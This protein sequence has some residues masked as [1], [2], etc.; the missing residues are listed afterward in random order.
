[1]RVEGMVR[2]A[3]HECTGLLHA[4][5]LGA[6]IRITQAAIQA[7][8]VVPAAIGRRVSGKVRPKDG[9]KSVDR[10][11]GNP[12]LAAERWIVFRALAARM[13]NEHSIPV[14][15][16]DWT[17]PMGT[18]QA[19]VAAIPIGGRSLPLYIEVHPQNKLS[20]VDVESAFLT[21]LSKVLPPGCRPIVVSDA[22]FKGPFFLKVLE[23]G[24][25]FVGRIRG[26]A[27]AVTLDGVHT[28]SKEQ[29]YERATT[30]PQNLGIYELFVDQRIP[31]RLVLVRKRRKPG[32]KAPPPKCKEERELRQAA[33]DPWLLATSLAIGEAASTVALYAKRMQIEEMFR[34]AKNHRFGWSLADAR[35]ASTS[36]AANLLVV[37]AVALVVV[38]LLG[39]AAE[40]RHVHRAYQANTRKRRVLSFF[41]LGCDIV[42][43]RDTTAVPIA[44]F[45]AAMTRVWDL[46]S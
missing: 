46:A 28:I 15:L 31:V 17:Q 16:I 37:T 40:Q 27:K 24:W 36:R 23:L 34:D 9:I 13:L 42:G 30:T 32:P 6:L 19:L 22:G 41:R 43:R 26:T 33:L 45:V 18:H 4:K 8:R 14:V 21:M 11:L 39:L 35:T 7:G 12:R 20:N 1:M 25:H 3:L 38:T 2:K 5:R 10:L 29:F 44:N